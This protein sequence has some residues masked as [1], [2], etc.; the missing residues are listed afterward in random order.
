VLFDSGP[1]LVQVEY[2]GTDRRLVGTAA[3]GMIF[4]TMHH[5]NAVLRLLASEIATTNLMKANVELL[6]RELVHRVGNLLAVAQGSS[7]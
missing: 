5:F 1:D 4:R 3:Y 2:R 6:N 7:N